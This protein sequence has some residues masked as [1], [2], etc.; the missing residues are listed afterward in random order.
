ML[1]S[2]SKVPMTY[3]LKRQKKSYIILLL[4][5]V[6][7]RVIALGI[8]SFGRPNVAPQ[9]MLLE[10]LDGLEVTVASGRTNELRYKC[11]LNGRCYLMHSYTSGRYALLHM[12]SMGAL[13]IDLTSG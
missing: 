8:I 7:V 13:V 6:I 4:Y 10:K 11:I 3:W 9:R 2:C 1:V 5:S 12:P